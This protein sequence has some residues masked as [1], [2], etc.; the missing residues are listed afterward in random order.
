MTTAVSVLVLGFLLGMRHAT[1]P[2]HV[3]AV[4]TIVARQRRLWASAIVGAWWGLGHTVTIFL[5]GGAIIALHLVVPARIGLA[6]ECAVALMLIALGVAT[7]KSALA[8]P[9]HPAAAAPLPG[10]DQIGPLRPLLVGIVHGLAGSAAAALLILATISDA[11]WAAAYLAVFGLGT[12]AGMM[13]LT[14]LLGLP[15]LYTAT[16]F[17]HVHVLLAR[18]TGLASVAL[19]LLLAYRFVV[20]GGLFSSAPRWTPE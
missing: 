17:A 5:V 18:I 1:D 15:F 8:R 4:T 2:D 3:V 19:G 9:G 6:M 10:V 20:T 16:R 14:T 13:A 11:R 12:V 7:L